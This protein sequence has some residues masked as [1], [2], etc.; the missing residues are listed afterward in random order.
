MTYDELL[1]MYGNL[2]I[3]EIDLSGVDPEGEYE[4]IYSD[5]RIYIRS[6]IP[7]T[8]Q[9]ACIL[10]EEVGHHYTTVGDILDQTDIRNAKQENIAMAWAY[11][12]MIPL[13]ALVEAYWAGITTRYELA[14]FLGVTEQFLQESLDYFKRKYDNYYI[15]GNCLICFDPLAVAELKGSG[16]DE[17]QKM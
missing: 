7:T 3:K 17:M 15:L 14:E 1:A 2:K 4:G 10:A 5:G 9:K 13:H 12:E 11:E 8:T 6:D 16:T